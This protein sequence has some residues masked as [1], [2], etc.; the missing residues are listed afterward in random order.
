MISFSNLAKEIERTWNEQNFNKSNFAD[1]AFNCLNEFTNELTLVELEGQI[2][3]LILENKLPKQLNVYSNFGQPPVTI[4]NNGRFVVDLYFWQDIDTSIHSH[5]FSGAF[6]VLFGRSFHEVFEVNPIKKFTED[7][8]STDISITSSDLLKQGST[9]KIVSGNSFNHRVVHL[10]M[11]TVTLCV[12]TIDDKDKGQWHHFINGLSI[13]KRE[14]EESQI[15][16][17]FYFE[18]S[19]VRNPES[20][21]KFISELVENWDKS[22]VMNIFEQLLNDGMGLKPDTSEWL[23]NFISNNYRELEWFGIYEEYYSI[24]EEYYRLEGDSASERFIEVAMNLPYSLEQSIPILEK[25]QNSTATQE[26]IDQ[27]SAKL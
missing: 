16:S 27:L 18:Y 20:A 22:V 21:I 4:F 9:Q 24:M 1:I 2:Q 19:L 17:L 8:M 3:N 26:Q 12:R 23:I 25:I 11:P 5:S 10:D 14:I 7:I 13:Q 6:K 15:K